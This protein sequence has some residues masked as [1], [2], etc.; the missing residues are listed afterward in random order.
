[1]PSAWAGLACVC[2]HVQYYG[3]VIAMASTEK[4]FDESREQSRVKAEI[5]QKYFDTWAGIITATQNRSAYGGDR[6][7]YI[8]LFAGPGRY[9]D[10]ASSTPLR[11]LEKAIANPTYA[12]RLVT[13]FNDG[14]PANAST[15]REEIQKLPG[16]ET[17]KFA[18]QVNNHEVGD[19][20]AEDI[21]NIKKVPTLAF[22]DPWGY[23]GLTLKLVDAF[24]RDWGCDCIF[25]FNYARINAGLN[26]PFVKEHME[27]LF[28]AEPAA[29][30]GEQLKPMTPPEREAT[31][32]NALAQALKTF[33]HRFVLPFCFKN[34]RGTRT[35]H[36]L[37]LVTK[38]F[39]GYEVMKDIMAKSS[40]SSDQGVPTFTYSAAASSAQPLLF[41]LN[42]PLDDLRGMLLR[43]FAAQTLTMRQIYEQ[44]SVDRPYVSKNYKDVLT[45]MET[46]GAI[47]TE[48]RKSKRGFADDIRVTFPSKRTR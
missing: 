1:M 19:K 47:K 2:T 17:L 37:I 20:I 41:E 28:G 40:S 48:G 21:A 18:P 42:R 11:V 36:H 14:D 16:I 12:Q 45:K 10:G 8:D 22:I 13:I 30:L 38:A 6:I 24:L 33:G 25:F 15:L 44:H 27:A 4:F 29:A 7:A 32:V 35:S 31:I 39:K 3:R 43:D 23:K 5:V 34:E 9:K 46:D 26:N